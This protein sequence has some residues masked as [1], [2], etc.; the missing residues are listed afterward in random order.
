MREGLDSNWQAAQ[1]KT[2]EK[3]NQMVALVRML[4]FPQ[5]KSV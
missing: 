2:V 3:E 1:M 4:H 5:G